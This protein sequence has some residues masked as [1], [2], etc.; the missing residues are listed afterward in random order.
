MSRIELRREGNEIH[1]Q[2]GWDDIVLYDAEIVEL[3]EKLLELKE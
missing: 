2:I 1:L 3:I